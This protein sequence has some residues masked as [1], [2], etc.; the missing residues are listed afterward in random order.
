MENA[1]GAGAGFA[2]PMTRKSPIKLPQKRR[3]IQ[4]ESAASALKQR[5]P[6]INEK[7]LDDLFKD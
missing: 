6:E 1:E 5:F 4:A 3:H 7:M 2:V